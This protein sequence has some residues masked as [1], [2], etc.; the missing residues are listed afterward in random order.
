MI[1]ESKLDYEGIG[2]KFITKVV[3]LKLKII[4]KTKEIV[5][6]INR[7]LNIEINKLKFD[8]ISK[9]INKTH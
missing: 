6:Q 9:I 8:I 1:F 2:F 7:K 4:I 5:H 3:Q